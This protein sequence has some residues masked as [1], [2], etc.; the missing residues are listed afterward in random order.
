MNLSDQLFARLPAAASPTG[1]FP[2]PNHCSLIGEALQEEVQGVNPPPVQLVIEQKKV[3]M[4]KMLQQNYVKY[5]DSVAA[6]A[7]RWEK[8]DDE[9]EEPLQNLLKK[10][11]SGGCWQT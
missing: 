2:E 4:A 8:D 5:W 9:D 1:S 7:A 6:N 10:K 11:I 3:A